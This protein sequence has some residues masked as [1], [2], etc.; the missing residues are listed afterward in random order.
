MSRT[1]GYVTLVITT[2]VYIGIFGSAELAH[3]EP[4][5]LYWHWAKLKL[6]QSDCGQ[7]AYRVS[8]VGVGR[9]TKRG[10]D[11]VWARNS[12]V[13]TTIQCIKLSRKKSLAVMIVT[14][15]SSSQA[16]KTRDFLKCGMAGNPLTGRRG[17]GEG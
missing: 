14:S 16:K 7:R 9:P 5:S 12:R 2:I 1:K 15:N 10:D 4:P 13:N 17:C 8:S 11:T 6:K 3:A